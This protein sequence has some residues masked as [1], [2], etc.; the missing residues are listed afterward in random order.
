VEKRNDTNRET[1]RIA[2]TVMRA[3]RRGVL[4]LETENARRMMRKLSDLKSV[5][6]DPPVGDDPAPATT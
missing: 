5:E 4:V 2:G 3:T 1:R 6:P